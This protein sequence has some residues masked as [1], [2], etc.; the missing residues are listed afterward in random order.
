MATSASDLY[1]RALELE[2]TERAKLAGLLLDS[3]DGETE[4]GVDAAWLEEVERR[5]AELD[6]GV[7][8]PTPWEQVRARI[9]AALDA[10]KKP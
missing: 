4:E 2:E 6:S 8:E 10:S 3:L 1:Q 5:M 9:V 7:V